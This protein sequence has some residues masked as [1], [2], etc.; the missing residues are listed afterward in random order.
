MATPREPADDL[1]RIAFL[2]ERAREPTYRVRALRNAAAV[3]AGL[4]QQELAERAAAG[5]LAKLPGIG[6]VTA[7]C[8]SESLR[9]EMPVYLLRLEETEDE[10]FRET[11]AYCRDR[12]G[13]KPIEEWRTEISE[14]IAAKLEAWR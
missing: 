14:K 3:A 8:I 13:F 10:L 4:S 5:T 12:D 9:G 2:L 6:D 11:A 1:R 7:R